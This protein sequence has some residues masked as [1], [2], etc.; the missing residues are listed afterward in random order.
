M[1]AKRKHRAT[2]QFP[3]GGKRPG[4]GRPQGTTNVLEYGAVSALKSL[5]HR[6]PEGI[7]PELADIAGEAFQRMVAVMRGEVSG[8]DAFPVLTAAKAIRE[9]VCGPIKQKLEVGGPD[10]GALQVSINI[11]RDEPVADVHVDTQLPSTPAA[12]KE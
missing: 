7:A 5:R 8:S 12:P 1:A 10:G 2:G 3:P 6:V 11:R 9:D 4:A